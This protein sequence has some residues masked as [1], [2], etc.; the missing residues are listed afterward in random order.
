MTRPGSPSRYRLGGVL[1]LLAALY[2]V[3]EAWAIAGWEG[4]P[5]RWTVDAISE[6]GVPETRH[7]AGEAFRATH[8]AVMNATFIGSGVRVLLVGATLAP[9]VP[10]RGRRTVL[11]L[12]AAYGLGL[13]VVGIFPTGLP[14]LRTSLHGVGAALALLGGSALLVA[15]TASLW[16]RY[17]RLA[18]VTLVLAA[19]SVAGNVC[20]VLQIGGFGLVERVSVYAVVA[21]QV[22]V[23]VL[24]LLRRP[25][26]P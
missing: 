9:F 5:Y 4:R 17:R 8:H 26:Q 14:S 7:W 25:P 19:A 6:L 15:L 2:F 20:A 21:W 3:G 23:G 10:R 11:A 16:V 12:V 22:L 24:I 18:L 1:L 13:V